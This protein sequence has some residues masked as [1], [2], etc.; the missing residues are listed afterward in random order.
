MSTRQEHLQAIAENFA[1][2]KYFECEEE[3][4]RALKVGVP[5]PEIMKTL[6]SLCH[7]A[8]KKY[9]Q[10]EYCIPHLAASISIFEMGSDLAK[11]EVTPKGKVVV[12]TLGSSHYLG[13]DIIGS[14]LAIDGF[15]VVD[16]GELVSP[17]QVIEAVVREK[18]DI[19]VLSV[20]IVAC[21]H[22]QKMTIQSLEAEGLRKEVKVMIGGSVTSE[23]W[24]R[25]IAADAWAFN[26]SGAIK[27]ANRL[28]GTG[29]MQ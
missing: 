7:Q 29:C 1:G 8:L 15:E 5:E 6:V 26:A 11:V 23:R 4:K 16:L 24:A 13:K 18:P 17:E 9:E 14:L 21:L 28:M 10:G 2:F 25:E 3:I 19:L 27:E 20:L 12:C 22:L